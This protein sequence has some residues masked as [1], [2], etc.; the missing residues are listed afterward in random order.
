[1][2]VQIR[3]FKSRRGVT[4]FTGACSSLINNWLLLR[5]VS[6]SIVFSWVLER[7]WAIRRP[8][9]ENTRSDEAGVAGTEKTV[10]NFL[11]LVLL[12]RLLRP[13]YVESLLCF[14][15]VVLEFRVHTGFWCLWLFGRNKD[16]ANQNGNKERTK[17]RSTVTNF[18]QSLRVDYSW[19]LDYVDWLYLFDLYLYFDYIYFDPLLYHS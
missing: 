8:L 19:L 4:V 6:I 13:N 11:E 16:E 12:A 15:Q 3:T 18:N 7:R 1:M 9:F 10:G 5:K 14:R 2:S 17:P